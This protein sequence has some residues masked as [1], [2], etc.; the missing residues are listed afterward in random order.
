MVTALLESFNCSGKTVQD[1][2]ST[3]P[4]SIML[5]VKYIAGH[6][7]YNINFNQLAHSHLPFYLTT[8]ASILRILCAMCLAKKYHNKT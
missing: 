4:R 1:D 6:Q 2:P 7:Y 3:L 8:I 5:H